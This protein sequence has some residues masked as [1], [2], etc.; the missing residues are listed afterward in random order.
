MSWGRLGVLV[1]VL[2][3]PIAFG[4]A[5]TQNGAGN[6]AQSPKSALTVQSIGPAGDVGQQAPRDMPG[7]GRQSMNPKGK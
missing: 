6:P 2:A 1:L 5:D 3:V 7:G 4:C